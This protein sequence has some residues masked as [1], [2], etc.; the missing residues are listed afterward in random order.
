M[1]PDCSIVLDPK[2]A[3]G[4]E[5]RSKRGGV[6]L[7]CTRSLSCG[8][9]FCPPAAATAGAISI[10][11]AAASSMLSEDTHPVHIDDITARCFI[12]GAHNSTIQGCTIRNESVQ[13]TC[14][15]WALCTQIQ[16]LCSNTEKISAVDI[17][18]TACT[19]RRA[20]KYNSRF[21]SID[22]NATIGTGRTAR[23]G[24]LVHPVCTVEPSP[25]TAATGADKLP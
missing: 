20:L 10:A 16:S 13:D 2:A 12:D 4:C 5:A 1:V 19:R 22:V 9:V 11:A 17:E 21:I 3:C 14:V 6:V 18:H 25:D 8:A 7:D 23:F 24:S 15:N